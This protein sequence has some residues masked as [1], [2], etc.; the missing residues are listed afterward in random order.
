MTRT[1]VLAV[2]AVVAALFAACELVSIATHRRYTGVQGF[3]DRIGGASNRRLVVLFVG[4]MW[5]GWHFF[6]R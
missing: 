1:A 3:L 2:W 6:A 5:V 4:W